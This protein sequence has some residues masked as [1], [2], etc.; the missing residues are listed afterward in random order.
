M[1]YPPTNLRFCSYLI[2]SQE[3]TL[4]TCAHEIGHLAFQWD[5]FYDPGFD[6]NKW[7]GSGYWDLMGSGLDLEDGKVPSHP[8]GLHKMCHKWI[9]IDEIKNL[10]PLT[11]YSL[12]PYTRNSGKVLKL[13]SPYYNK[14]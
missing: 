6:N 12:P 1:F 5:D 10:T 7:Y 4:G 3:P 8:A 9:E 2:V 13:V 11:S 14:R